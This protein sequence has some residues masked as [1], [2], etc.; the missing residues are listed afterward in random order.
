MNHAAET[1]RFLHQMAQNALQNRPP[2]GLFRDFVTSAADGHPGTIDLKLNG[3]M[4]FTDAARIYSLAARI[5][6]TNTCERLRRYGTA[7]NVPGEEV[8]AWI[9]AFLFIQTLRL[10]QQHHEHTHGRPLSNRVAPS[11]LNLME[12][13]TLKEALRLARALQS[14]LALDYGL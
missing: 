7:G 4:L 13:N 8:H 11:R 3:A 5:P 14:R 12:R 10:R 1:P 2:L 9:D 6:H